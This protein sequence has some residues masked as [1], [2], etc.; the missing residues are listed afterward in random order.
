MPAVLPT[1]PHVL[2]GELGVETLLGTHL[3]VHKVLQEPGQHTHTVVR[4]ATHPPITNNVSSPPPPH[5]RT[6]YTRHEPSMQGAH[7]LPSAMRPQNTKPIYFVRSF[8]S[9]MSGSS[10]K[11]RSTTSLGKAGDRGATKVRGRAGAGGGVLSE[12]R[13]DIEQGAMWD[14]V[15]DSGVRNAVKQK[16][17]S[18]TEQGCAVVVRRAGLETA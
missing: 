9:C 11:N 14:G 7:R 3:L 8:W 5:S 12:R 1:I 6:P 4:S 10:S 15:D 18:T 17:G 16:R 2:S 13:Y